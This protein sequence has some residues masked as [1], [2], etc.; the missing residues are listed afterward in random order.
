[1]HLEICVE[2]A[3]GKILLERVL[4]KIIRDEVTFRIHGYKGIGHVPKGLKSTDDAEK[5]LFLDNL[6]KLIRGCARTPHVTAFDVTP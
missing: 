4:P 6:P 2:D 3:S 5:R 1:M